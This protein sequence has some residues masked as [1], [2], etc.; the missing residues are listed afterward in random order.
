MHR[1]NAFFYRFAERLASS[2]SSISTSESRKRDSKCIDSSYQPLNELYSRTK[3]HFSPLQ[4]AYIRGQ[5]YSL[6]TIHTMEAIRSWLNEMLDE[7]PFT[8]IELV[9][10]E[11]ER[12]IAVIDK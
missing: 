12:I 6:Q 2:S 5:R 4:D 3:R 8:G 1:D 9:L 10:D 7:D 11:K